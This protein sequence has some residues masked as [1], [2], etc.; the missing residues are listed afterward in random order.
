MSD[1][2]LIEPIGSRP[3]DV[4]RDTGAV[5][6]GRDGQPPAND[7]RPSLAC[8][9][10][11]GGPSGTRPDGSIIPGA[12]WGATSAPLPLRMGSG[13]RISRAIRTV[14]ALAIPGLGATASLSPP[15]VT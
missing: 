13:G 7:R 6:R 5:L 14:G 2:F 9:D 12:I 1:R 11:A 4:I 15:S 8:A 3:D 10:P